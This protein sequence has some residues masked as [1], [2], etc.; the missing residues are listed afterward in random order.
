MPE[1][2][3]SP[4]KIYKMPKPLFSVD[5]NNKTLIISRESAN[6][7]LLNNSQ[8]L[9]IFNFLAEGNNVLEVFQHFPANAQK[10]IYHVLVELEAK[11]FEDITVQYP[12]E[13]GM[14][15]YL[16][17]K[18]NQRCH[19]C[20]MY[21]GETT[22]QELATSEVERLLKDFSAV[23]GKV[24]TFT[25]GEVTVRSDFITILETAKK[26]GL[27]VCV[28]TNGVLWDQSFVQK[29]A[30][31][32]DEVQVSIDGYDAK[33]YCSVRGSNAFDDVLAAVN[34]LIE[35]GIRVTVA[36][37]PLLGT[38]LGNEKHYIDFANT[39]LAKYKGKEFFVK[40]NT[41]LMDGRD[42]T[43]TEEENDRYRD[44]MKSIKNQCS[45]F[46]EE[47]GFA[48]DHRNNTIFNNCGYGGLAIAANGDVY[49]CNLISKCAKQGNVRTDLFEDIWKKSQN[50]RAMSDVNKLVPCRECALKYICGGGCRVKNFTS[51]SNTIIVDEMN[52]N[53][54]FVRD[55]ICTSAYKERFY[56][57]MIAANSLFYR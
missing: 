27:I 16:T 8:Q 53:T 12:Q 17:N 49:F 39:L 3:L 42:I 36:V 38:L 29:A 2:E 23:G 22:A 25:G 57:L 51:L 13:H 48:I 6:W 28:L 33:S 41:E 55:T 20:Y 45:P 52:T 26:L 15:V 31:Y 4:T 32:I 46:S 47:E 5:Y 30:P 21:A 10:D 7:I 56:Q 9:A 50:A 37:T 40:F 24:I 43:P 1:L 44:A 18:C 35:A 54:T 19:H 14:Y 34:R 11:R